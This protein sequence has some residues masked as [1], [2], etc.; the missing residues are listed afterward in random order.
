MQGWGRHSP[1]P[2]KPPSEAQAPAPRPAASLAARI[3][4]AVPARPSQL[5]R[6]GAARDRELGLIAQGRL[7]AP[8]GGQFCPGCPWALNP[9]KPEGLQ[10]ARRGPGFACLT[11][12]GGD[13]TVPSRGSCEADTGYLAHEEVTDQ[14]SPLCWWP[15]A[16]S[17]GPV[18]SPGLGLR[19]PP[20]VSAALSGGVDSRAVGLPPVFPGL[21]KPGS[22]SERGTGVSH[23][24]ARVSPGEDIRPNRLGVTAGLLPGGSRSTSSR[25]VRAAPEERRG[26]RVP[27]ARGPQ[28]SSGPQ[29]CPLLRD[30]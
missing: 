1:T 10:G 20:A 26:T 21:E 9:R 22:V 29:L 2:R 27:S 19:V 6:E 25:R 12:H 14:H 15:W 18:L 30:P 3:V 28:G 7:P 23:P 16:L 24:H 5:P 11:A 17:V 13:S 4:G 8:R